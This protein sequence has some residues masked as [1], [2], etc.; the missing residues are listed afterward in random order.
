MPR[1]SGTGPYGQGPGT[2]I[3]LGSGRGRVRMGEHA[4]GR[5]LVGAASVPTAALGF[6]IRQELRVT[7]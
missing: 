7:T 5:G 4:P 1:G 6:P 3:G 2:G